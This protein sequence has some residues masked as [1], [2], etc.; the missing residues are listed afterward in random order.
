MTDTD[1]ALLILAKG[2]EK[3]QKDISE[4]RELFEDNITFIQSMGDVADKMGDILVDISD[5]YS[6]SIK[7]SVDQMRRTSE[8]FKNTTSQ[9]YPQMNI[10]QEWFSEFAKETVCM[11]TDYEEPYIQHW[12]IVK[13]QDIARSMSKM[14]HEMT[15]DERV[16]FGER[17]FRMVTAELGADPMCHYILRTLYIPYISIYY[18]RPFTDYPYY[19]EWRADIKRYQIMKEVREEYHEEHPQAKVYHL[20]FLQRLK[21]RVNDDKGLIHSHPSKSHE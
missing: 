14:S 11:F 8:F 3:V 16:E 18:L 19:K 2:T 13:T 1:E 7:S 9:I 17:M 21:D 6:A 12:M 15:Y 5:N 4:L 20:D 10:I